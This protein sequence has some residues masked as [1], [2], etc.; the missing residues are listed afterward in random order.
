MR[1]LVLNYEFPP[2]GGGASPISYELT[3]EFVKAGHEV[4]VITMGFRDLPRLETINKNFRIHRVLCL[5]SKK[6]ISHPWEQLTYLLSAYFYC[7]RLLKQQS[8]DI[9]Y[10]HFIIPT[11]ILARWLKKCF[12][13]P[14]IIMS[15]GSDVL[16]HNPRFKYLYPLLC[17]SWKRILV[18]AKSVVVPSESLKDKI[19]V[20][21]HDLPPTKIK[22]IPYG[23]H[24]NNFISRT[25]EPYLLLVT[26]LFINKGIQDFLAAI[27]PLKLDYW[28][29]KIVGDGPYRPDLER[30]VKHYGLTDRVDFIGW[31]DRQNP[32]LKELYS[33]ASIFVSPSYFESF[34]LTVL[35]ALASGAVPLV[36]DIPSYRA[37]VGHNELLFKPGDPS[38]LRCKLSKLL[39]LFNHRQPL[40]IDC[41][42]LIKPFVWSELVFR[43]LEL[44]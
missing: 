30:L 41:V 1:I 22:V 43:Y 32:R 11:G 9:C 20:A 18:V 8:Y 42:T 24:L 14:Y 29:V 44:I 36:S 25:K 23:I 2:L 15:H 27:Y 37:M 21:H 6:E 5:R 28:R 38:D 40:P 12:A 16:D 10:A 26:R 7:R 31:L 35:E 3:A 4:D 39:D 13:L 17:Q 34:G 19:F 33:H